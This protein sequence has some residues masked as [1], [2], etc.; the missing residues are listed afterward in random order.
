MCF[1]L[2]KMQ[3]NQLIRFCELICWRCACGCFFMPRFHC[4]MNA[5]DDS[6]S[7]YDD[8]VS[9]SPAGVF[10][11]EQN[12]KSANG[13][14]KSSIS[15]RLPSE[16]VT[17]IKVVFTFDFYGSFFS[18]SRFFAINLR[19][20]THSTRCCIVVRF[21]TNVKT[22]MNIYYAIRLFIPFRIIHLSLLLGPFLLS[23][24]FF[25]SIRLQSSFYLS[26]V[27]FY[28]L[29]HDLFCVDFGV[30]VCFFS[31][32]WWLVECVVQWP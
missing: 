32:S 10:F 30:S 25:F 9:F 6:W 15:K 17:S 11:C 20:H 7:G 3:K 14:E 2:R 4:T 22:Y 29:E 31:Q 13:Y 28:G 21:D 24:F 18:C 8:Q 16:N 1:F 12:G 5:R 27:W 23:R 26:S 19:R